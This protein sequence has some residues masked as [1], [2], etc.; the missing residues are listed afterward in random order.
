[1]ITKAQKTAEVVEF[2]RLR[3]NPKMERR[4][5]GMCAKDGKCFEVCSRDRL[6]INNAIILFAWELLTRRN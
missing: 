4:A 3:L 2:D 1:M 5:Y 6:C